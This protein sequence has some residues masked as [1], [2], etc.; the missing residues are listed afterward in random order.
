MIRV[1][2]VEIGSQKPKICVPITGRTCEEILDEARL[3][4][5]LEIDMVEW[6]ADYSNIIGDSET[7]KEV[8]KDLRA[9]L[10]DKII[11]FTF[12]TVQEGGEQELSLE[13]YLE[14]NQIVAKSGYVDFIDL[15][16]YSCGGIITKTVEYVH[17]LGCRVILS[18]HDFKQTPKESI[19]LERFKEM[20]QA[21]ADIAKI[22]VMPQSPED[23]LTLLS[24]TVKANQVLKCPVVS[25][26]MSKLGMVSRVTGELFG[27]AIT[28][29]CA[30]KSSAPGQVPVKQLRSMLDIF[31]LAD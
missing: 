25:M 29:G 15:E 8:L 30:E 1:R 23:V 19:L 16:I 12:R 17:R 31:C 14:L 11:L 26:S 13:A 9:I 20:E 18:N 24:V 4:R 27:S 7:L 6:R 5:E 3:I 10:G 28:F 21:G 22:A 2:N